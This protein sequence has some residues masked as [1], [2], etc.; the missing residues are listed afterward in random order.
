MKILLVGS[1][2]EYGIE[3]YYIKHL[4]ELGSEIVHYP[5]P[6]L[7]YRYR[8]SNLVNKILSKA[9]LR[10][11]YR[12]V[13]KELIRLAD[14]IKPDIIWIFKGMEIYPDTLKLLGAKYK[15]ANYN[16][17]HPFIISGP[18]SG[19]KNVTSSVGLYDFHFSYNLSLQKQIGES[20][21]LKTAFLPFGFELPEADFLLAQQQPEINAIGFIGNPD[22]TR[23]N[24]IALLAAN[25]FRVDVYGHGWHR[26]SLSKLKN[27]NIYDAVYGNEF[28]WKLRQYRVQ[29]NIFRKHNGGSHNM[30]SFEIPAAGGIQLTPFS[31]EQALFFEEG[32]EIFFYRN[33]EDLLKQAGNLL[34]ASAAEAAV[35]REAARKR[36]VDSHYSYYDRAR[37]VQENFK[38]LIS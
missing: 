10:K 37:I 27:V 4:R 8:S 38:N 36:S 29:L 32:K 34:S 28:W 33:E 11:G 13:N 22:K 15:L 9:G 35:Y 20:F 2:F 6:D 18:G 12:K 19:N 26:T 5:A 14:H 16:P 17:D 24:R 31:D 1:D 30:R 21:H 3:Q 7:V 23:V 25:G